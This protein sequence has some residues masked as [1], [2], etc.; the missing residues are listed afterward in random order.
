LTNTGVSLTGCSNKSILTLSFDSDLDLSSSINVDENTYDNDKYMSKLISQDLLESINSSFDEHLPKDEAAGLSKVYPFESSNDRKDTANS[1]NIS[2]NSFLLNKDKSKNL[3]NNG[4]FRG[5]QTMRVASE[6]CEVKMEDKCSTLKEFMEM[7]LKM[8][9]KCENSDIQSSYK[10]NKYEY[11]SDVHNDFNSINKGKEYNALRINFQNDNV[12]VKPMPLTR[13]GDWICKNCK[14]LN[15]VFRKVC[16]RC[17]NT[18]P[19]NG[20]FIHPQQHFKQQAH[21]NNRIIKCQEIYSW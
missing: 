6:Q 14:N 13:P 10:N 8:V 21:L 4:I 20:K 9:D 19:S 12:A 3:Y 15:F 17:N 1:E 7:S 16:N 18:K 2:N 5:T 11:S